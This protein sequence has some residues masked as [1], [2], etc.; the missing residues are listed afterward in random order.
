MTAEMNVAGA[1]RWATAIGGAALAVYGLKQLKDE[2]SVPGAM[3][4]AAE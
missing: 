4:A 3:L 1:E 2:R